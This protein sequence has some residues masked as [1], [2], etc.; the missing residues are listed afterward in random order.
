MYNL[1][2][3]FKEF[4]N[5][6]VVLPEDEKNN[7]LNKKNLNIERLKKGLE[8]YNEE[9]GTNYKLAENPIIQGSMAMHTIIQNDKKD[10][11]I[12][13]AIMF[14]KDNIPEGRIATKNII[15]DALRRKCT[16]FKKEPEARTNCVRIEYSDGYHVDFAIYRRY[17]DENGNFIYE[18]CGSEWRKRDPR[19]ITQWFNEQNKA[20]DYKL[21]DVVRLLKMFSKSRDGW[22]NMPSGLIITVLANEQFQSYERMDERFYYT[23]KAIRDRLAVN[24]EV[25]NPVDEEQSLKLV[26]K[27]DVKINNFYNRLDE[28]L[29]KLDV[30]FKPNCTRIEA[31]QAWKEFFNHD[32]WE[33][34]IKREYQYYKSSIARKEYYDY[35][36]TEEFIE[37]YFPVNIQYDI[38]L[39]CWVIK[40]GKK[41]DLLSSFLK[42]KQPL[43]PGYKLEFF[44]KAK[45]IPQP[46]QI[47]W[48]IK[49]CG[50]EAKRR[51]MVRGEILR[52]NKPTQ[53][54]RT[55]F[56]GDHYVECY[57]IK[58]GVCVARRKIPVPIKA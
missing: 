41:I 19:A 28:N 7:L 11:D 8:E 10:Y 21:R 23:A 24:K 5:E 18:H 44:V 26:S 56:K 39:D 50:E 15:V 36:D 13:I 55:L 58:N 22:V 6:H 47:F 32:Y 31:L 53:E 14:D 12:D 43:I 42:K 51:D 17:R 9:H 20:K 35:R 3:E 49:N 25:N 34:L 30:L 16:G 4:Y 40:N 1:N 57:I 37:D 38:E 2:D 33:E 46:Y 54:E 27:D 48:K 45:N 29:A 52:T